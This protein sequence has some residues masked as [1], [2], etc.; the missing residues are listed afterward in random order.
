MHKFGKE[1]KKCTTKRQKEAKR[2]V[3]TTSGAS[4][5]MGSS[6]SAERESTSETVAVAMVSVAESEGNPPK[7]T[8]ID[9]TF[10]S[11]ADCEVRQR[12]TEAI[13]TQLS[14]T[15]ATERK[16]KSLA[17]ESQ[18]PMSDASS[19]TATYTIIDLAAVNSLLE[20]TSCCMC[21][22]A[23]NIEREK[24]EFGIAVKL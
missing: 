16:T 10:L 23:V 13:T 5:T 8:R 6:P 11:S 18:A 22:G 4:V 12:Q 7:R 1:K 19:S 17:T 9:S 3:S 14:S 2:S 15:S 21:R 24:R 20:F